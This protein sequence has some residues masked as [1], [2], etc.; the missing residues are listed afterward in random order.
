MQPRNTH[1]FD[2]ACL[3][4]GCLQVCVRATKRVRSIIALSEAQ[5]GVV[6]MFLFGG[7]AR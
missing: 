1:L 4:P 2:S 5:L 7:G 3:K 6:T